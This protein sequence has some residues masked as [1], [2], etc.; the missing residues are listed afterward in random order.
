MCLFLAVKA[1]GILASW[2]GLKPMLAALDGEVL[3]TGPPGK[4]LFFIFY[5]FSLI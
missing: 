2:P 1:S 3:T 5:F 4:T